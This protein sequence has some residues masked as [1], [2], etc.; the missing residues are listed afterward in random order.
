MLLFPRKL[1]QGQAQHFKTHLS[2]IWHKMLAY[3]L[4]LMKVSILYDKTHENFMKQ[5]D[6]VDSGLSQCIRGVWYSFSTTLRGLGCSTYI[7]PETSPR[8]QRQRYT[9]HIAL[10]QE[11]FL[12]NQTSTNMLDAGLGLGGRIPDPVIPGGFKCSD[13]GAEGTPL[14]LAIALLPTR[15]TRMDTVVDSVYAEGV[16]FISKP[17]LLPQTRVWMTAWVRPVY[18]N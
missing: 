2:V 5:A 17:A 15:M 6:M 3:L 10:V 8:H 4:V 12:Q 13:S 16:S 14:P 1:W 7:S 18:P 9:A 11:E